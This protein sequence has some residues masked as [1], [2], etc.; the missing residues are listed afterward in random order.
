MYSGKSVGWCVVISVIIFGIIGFLI[1]KSVAWH[2]DN[3]YFNADEKLIQYI[4]QTYPEQWQEIE[5][6]RPYIEYDIIYSNEMD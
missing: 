6:S 3:K 1:G 5:K 4:K 2:E